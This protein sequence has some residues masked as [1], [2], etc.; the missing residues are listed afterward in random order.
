MDKI[1]AV[2]VQDWVNSKW[3]D[4]KCQ[5]CGATN[6]SIGPSLYSVMNKTPDT[7]NYLDF[8]IISCRNCGNTLFLNP[9]VVFGE[10]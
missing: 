4:G 6:F 7:I 3:A 10:K 1:D 5:M 2:E 9:V 8:I